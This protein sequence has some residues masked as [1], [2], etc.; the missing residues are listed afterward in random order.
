MTTET[1]PAELAVR[2]SLPT[3]TPAVD[4]FES[5]EAIVLTLDVPGVRRD[6][7]TLEIEGDQLQINARQSDLPEGNLLH[8]GFAQV[9]FRRTFRLPRG[10]DASAVGASLENGVLR[11]TLPKA[12]SIRPRRIAVA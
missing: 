5:R 3:I 12:D 4:V 1:N 10:L 9:E 7:L 8:N 11:V 2:P 6:D